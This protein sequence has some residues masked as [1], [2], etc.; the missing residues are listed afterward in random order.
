MDIH[1]NAFISYRHH[2]EDIRVATEVQ[3][4]LERFHIPKAVRKNQKGQMK[5]FRDKDELPITSNLSDNITMALENSD[6]LIVI[7]ST[8]TRESLWVQR[9]I[10]T[11]LKTHTYDQVLTVLVDGDPYD[12]IP[13]I[14]L[15]RDVV[16]PVTGAVNKEPLE[17]LSCD[18]RLGKKQAMRE[19]LPRLAAVLLGCS[20]DELRQRQRQ[21]KMRRMMTILGTATAASL[22]LMA[23]FLYTSIIIQQA[24]DDLHAAN[25]EISRANAEIVAANEEISQANEEIRQANVQIQAN[26]EEAL[27][28][29]SQYLSSAAAER[30]TAGDRMTAIS[31]A[32]AALPTAENP[33]PYVPAAELTLT[34]ALGIYTTERNVIADGAMD[35]GVLITDFAVTADGKL[36]YTL[37]GSNRITVWDTHTYAKL[38]TMEYAEKDHEEMITVGENLILRRFSTDPALPSVSCYTPRG[39]LLWTVE[40]CVDLAMLGEETVLLMDTQTSYVDLSTETVLSFLDPVTGVRQREDLRFEKEGK[41]FYR[42]RYAPGSLL[43]M[44]FGSWNQ[45]NLYLLDLQDD[46]VDSIDPIAVLDPEGLGDYYILS[47]SVT[48]QKDVLV[49]VADDSG[50]M[51]GVYMNLQLTSPANAKVLCFRGE[52]WALAWQ[53][54]I[55]S[56]NF[57]TVRTLE[58][59]PGSNNILCQKD[60]VFYV[61][62]SAD[63]RILARG[64]AED[65]VLTIYL[66]KD[67][68]YGVLENGSYFEYTYN[69]DI[70]GFNNC[71]AMQLMEAD[72]YRSQVAGG[73]FTMTP[74]ST[75]ITVYRTEE[76][77]AWQP[78]PQSPDGYLRWEKFL[79]DRVVTLTSSGNLQAFD[80]QSGECLWTTTVSNG[81]SVE[82]VSLSANGREL[83]AK[84]LKNVMAFDLDTGEMRNMEIQ[85][86]VND[87]YASITGFGLGGWDR[88]IYMLSQNNDL[89]YVVMDL[90][91]G[92]TT[93]Y[94]YAEALEGYSWDVGSKTGIAAISEDYAWLWDKGNLYELDLNTQALRPILEELTE[95]PLCQ[96][97]EKDN[98]LTVCAGNNIVFFRPGGWQLGTLSLG[99]AKGVHVSFR[100]GETLVLSNEAQL[101]RFDAEGNRLSQTELHVYTS[102]Y[103]NVA[104]A[105][106]KQMSINWIDTGGGDLILNVFGLGNIIDCNQ[107]GV[108]GYVLNYKGYD[109]LTDRV[110]AYTNSQLGTFP[111]YTTAQVLALAEEELNGYSLPQDM[112]DYYGIG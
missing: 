40:S 35:C 81:Y 82:F 30:Y 87:N 56:Y 57:S 36:M 3:R 102:F 65:N 77:N 46:S 13:E 63:G 100:K 67:C 37:D 15:Y 61:L 11:F 74:N 70:Y 79:G 44:N 111:R 68:A 19:E 66:E 25:E 41:S 24:N 42:D 5:L 91:T 2:P 72:I 16:D 7:C 84:D 71:R 96:Y 64:E 28:N 21:Y 17:P 86:T 51:N 112:K 12:T 49:M 50:D 69:P 38:T 97:H 101:L 99:T 110:V 18:W 104:P 4:A 22:C 27:R 32:V 75:H 39:E 48:E 20:Y 14:L 80:L 105:E 90:K 59:I 54:S 108:R 109:A 53:Q 8:H 10:E 88:Y 33:R 6:Y 43:T 60:N 107:W 31:L 58:P 1:Y 29:Q 94:L 55:Q 34:D 95:Y 78:F 89:Y 92:G 73:Y 62:D 98:L 76:E 93:T 23:Y 103:Y 26:L 52:N 47:V 45:A 83:Y 85:R 106:G 9:E